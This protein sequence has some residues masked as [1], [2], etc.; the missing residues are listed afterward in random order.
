MAQN[1][2]ADYRHGDMEVRD[3]LRTYEAFGTLYKW[4]SL[5]IGALVLFL[6]MSLGAHTGLLPALIVFVVVLSL[7]IWRLTSKKRDD[8]ETE[9]SGH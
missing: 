3:H 4:A 2:P 8:A 6:S 9:L 7:G 5:V 1:A